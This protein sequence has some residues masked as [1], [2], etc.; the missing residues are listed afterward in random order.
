M[1]F[2]YQKGITN[3]SLAIAFVTGALLLMNQTYGVR[4]AIKYSFLVSGLLG[5]VMNYFTA[6]YVDKDKEFNLIFWI[7]IFITYLA[8]VVKILHLPYY[9]FIIIIGAAITGFSYFFNPFS[10]DNEEEKDKLLDQ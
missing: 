2:N 10:K 9:Q 5:I 4:E 3:I 8:I 6:R 7:G 1:R